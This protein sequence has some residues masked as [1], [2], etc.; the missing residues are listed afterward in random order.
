[1]CDSTRAVAPLKQA[2]DALATANLTPQ[3]RRFVT[4]LVFGVTRR[5]GTLDA[6]L[7]PF[8]NTPSP[9]WEQA[10][11]LDEGNSWETNWTMDF[12]RM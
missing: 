8:V 10:F 2:D 7:K 1:M 4:Q 3:D 9:R 6:L 5:S 11:S 12:T